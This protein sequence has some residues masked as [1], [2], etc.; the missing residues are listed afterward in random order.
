MNYWIAS[1]VY[2]RSLDY[3]NISDDI[4]ISIPYFE[5]NEKFDYKMKCLRREVIKT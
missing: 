4:R 5:D 2:L 3:T 1:V